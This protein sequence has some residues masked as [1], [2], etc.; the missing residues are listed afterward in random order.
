[1]APAAGTPTLVRVAASAY[2]K[3]LLHAAKYPAAT[4]TGVLVGARGATVVVEDAIPLTHHWETLS[5]MTEAALALINAHL[6][7]TGRVVLGVYE[8]PA[9]LDRAD[10]ATT[11]R[12]LAEK[13]AEMSKESAVVLVVKSAD[14]LGEQPFH[15]SIAGK[16]PANVPVQVPDRDT[17][18]AAVKMDLSAQRW[19]RIADWDEHLEDA[20]K[21]WL[22]NASAGVE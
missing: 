3:L 11:T 17:V 6:H 16:D 12:A 2:R 10:A 18:I 14:I 5:P 4:V 13:I 19:K 7:G 20:T 8:V 1:M 22:T 21:D 9:D 15:A